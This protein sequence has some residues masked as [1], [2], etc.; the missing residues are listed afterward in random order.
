[1]SNTVVQSPTLF[2]GIFEKTL[3]QFKNVF[4]TK[5]SS[6]PSVA[7]PIFAP[8]IPINKST[9]PMTEN[10]EIENNIQKIKPVL[11]K[12]K[13]TKLYYMVRRYET[14]KKYVYV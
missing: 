13:G 14:E 11:N 8:E 5:I 12:I 10:F 7:T 4:S 2:Y 3:N 1:M 6:A 9:A